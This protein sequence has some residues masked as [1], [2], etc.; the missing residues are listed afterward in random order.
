VKQWQL[1]QESKPKQPSLLK[2]KKAAMLASGTVPMCKSQEHCSGGQS[3]TQQLRSD[4]EL[5]IGNEFALLYRILSPHTSLLPCGRHE[6]HN[7]SAV[8]FS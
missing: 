4:N 6:L 1:Q 2:L 5:K 3:L 7:T 8:G